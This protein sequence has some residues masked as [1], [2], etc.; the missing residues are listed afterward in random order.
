VTTEKY[1][2]VNITVLLYGS[3]TWL[4]R[5]IEE[6]RLEVISEQNAEDNDWT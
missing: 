5:V 2:T 6:H 1:K 4:Q 3:E